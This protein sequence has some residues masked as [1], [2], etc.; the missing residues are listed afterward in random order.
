MSLTLYFL[1]HGETPYTQYSNGSL[2]R[3]SRSR[4]YARRKADDPSI[5]GGLSLCPLGSN[6][7]QSDETSDRYRSTLVWRDLAKGDRAYLNEALQTREE[8]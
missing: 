2:L 4:T 3:D 5:Y 8:T 6:L 1:R 7:C